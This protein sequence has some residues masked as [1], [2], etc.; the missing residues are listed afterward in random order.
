VRP[1]VLRDGRYLVVGLLGQGTQAETLEAEDRQADRRVAIKRFLVRGARSW[2]DVELAEREAR[3]L[4]ELAHPNLPAYVEH[5]EEAGALYLV[6]ERV[7]GK[8]LAELGRE[9]GAVDT[10][11]IIRLL[12]DAANALDYLHSRVPPVIHRDIKPNNIIRRDDGAY[13]LVDFGSV[14][15]RLRPEGGS[16]VVGT[17]GY[18]APEQFQGHA[19][20]SSDV[21]AVG[22]TALAA[23]T[24]RQPE[25][26]P[27][28]GL[29]VDV[30]KALG[31]TV[32]PRLRRALSAMLEPDPERRP[33]SVAEALA[34]EG[35]GSPDRRRAKRLRLRRPWVVL[36]ALVLATAL[37]APIYWMTGAWRASKPAVRSSRATPH[38]ASEITELLDRGDPWSARPKAGACPDPWSRAAVDWSLGDLP[39]AGRNFLAARAA[40]PDQPLTMSELQSVSLVDRKAAAALVR[41]AKGEWYRGPEGAAHA[42]LEC[43]AL[44]LEGKERYC[45]TAAKRSEWL[46]HQPAY[47]LH[48]PMNYVR[49]RSLT[50]RGLSCGS[51]FPNL[52]PLSESVCYGNFGAGR[53]LFAAIADDHAGLEREL[54]VV[55]Q[56]MDR[57]AEMLADPEPGPVTEEDRG[58]I[59]PTPVNARF[60]EDWDK[61]RFDAERL[62]SV[63]AAAA[64]FGRDLGRMRRYLTLAEAH[65]RGMLEE[66]LAL[67]A[68][69]RRAPHPAESP[70]DYNVVDMELFALID[71]PRQADVVPKMQSLGYAS[72]A[73][74]AELF[75]SRPAPREALS[76]WLHAGL[77]PL[78]R[79]CGVMA[80][81]KA[82]FERRE[83]ARVVGDSALAERLGEIT[84]QLGA[85]LL[86]EHRAEPLAALDA[87]LVSE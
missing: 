25:E 1:K 24:G 10:R 37:A 7:P 20:P 65:S 44:L 72:P 6:M 59:A 66:H 61:A 82:N 46:H 78:C 45:P 4:R 17:F 55:D 15:D 33:A 69:D 76:R 73:R 3:V 68:G 18:M 60:K 36:G 62:L 13:V 34:E 50:E 85:V 49:R 64:W 11:E 2:K 84:R 41:R 47:A 32:E 71:G 70:G 14:R 81:L 74:V 54:A 35:L 27:H 26:L 19:R 87:L 9:R 67:V 52:A 86:D 31:R 12:E 43:V 80:L 38:C 79:S 29:T 5:F 8:T 30:G 40:E 83:A 77:V 21:Y 42:Q 39:A 23:L 28:R 75:S 48:D 63:A 51:F 58:L 56:L 53:A 16:T 22:A 57:L